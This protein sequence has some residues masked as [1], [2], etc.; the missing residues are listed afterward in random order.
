MKYGNRGGRG[1]NG[2]SS[3]ITEQ[4]LITE[5]NQFELSNIEANIYAMYIIGNFS[6]EPSGSLFFPLHGDNSLVGYWQINLNYYF[7]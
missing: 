6:L 7:K 3:Y 4:A 2:G 1:G 5:T